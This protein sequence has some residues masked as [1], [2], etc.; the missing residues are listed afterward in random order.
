MAALVLAA[1]GCVRVGLSAAS[2]TC[3]IASDDLS[4]QIES[5]RSYGSDLEV[6]Q[7]RLSNASHIRTEASNLGMGAPSSTELIVLPPDIVA[8][9][10]NGG[11]SLAGSISAIANRA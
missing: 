10:E 4:T 9:D 3:S 8:T 2:V 5:A 6:Q 11:L 7:S 1:L